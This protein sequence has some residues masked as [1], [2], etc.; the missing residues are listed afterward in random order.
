MML[1]PQAKRL[2]GH[3][4]RGLSDPAQQRWKAWLSEVGE[5][6]EHLPRDVAEIVLDA[7][8]LAQGRLEDRL[9]NPEIS[10][11][12]EADA[13]N[14]LGYVRAIKGTLLNEGLRVAAG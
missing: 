5:R 12:D 2:V 10:E 4:V 9:A 1:P 8:R 13:L 3:A 14:D 7:L 6:Q 11:D